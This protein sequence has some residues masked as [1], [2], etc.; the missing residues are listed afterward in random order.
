MPA[1]PVSAFSKL[2]ILI[3][4]DLIGG[5]DNETRKQ[6][7]YQLFSAVPDHLGIPLHGCRCPFG[8]F[9]SG[10]AIISEPV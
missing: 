9:Y 8:A 2:N 5:C 6:S 4:F 1:M 3:K 7:G 10:S